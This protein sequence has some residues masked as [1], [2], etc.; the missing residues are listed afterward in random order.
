VYSLLLFKTMVRNTAA[1]NTFNYGQNKVSEIKTVKFF[2]G[3][4]N[5]TVNYADAYLRKA[6]SLQFC[7]ITPTDNCV[8]FVSRLRTLEIKDNFGF[9]I[10]HYSLNN[11]DT[12]KVLVER[13]DCSRYLFSVVNGMNLLQWAV[14]LDK[15]VEVVEYI[16]KEYIKQGIHLLNYVKKVT[17][18]TYTY[19]LVNNTLTDDEEKPQGLGFSSSDSTTADIS[20]VS[21]YDNDANAG[22]VKSNTNV[23]HLASVNASVNSIKTLFCLMKMSSANLYCTDIIGADFS[24]SVQHGSGHDF[25]RT[26]N[27]ITSIDTKIVPIEILEL[28]FKAFCII[29]EAIIKQKE[30]EQS[31]CTTGASVAS[32][33]GGFGHNNNTHTP[34]FGRGFG[35]NNNT[36]TPLFGRGMLSY[37]IFN[38]SLIHI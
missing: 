8:P 11:V 23:L 30:L 16:A 15:P 5:V 6:I 38:L 3:V 36:H 20:I 1:V 31:M 22:I 19:D 9:N 29:K 34:L 27:T 14:K 26:L 32:V 37:D 2:R 4:N 13:C 18:V 33:R 12:L 7:G 10:L 28:A 35:H 21:N 25:I 24:N 17:P